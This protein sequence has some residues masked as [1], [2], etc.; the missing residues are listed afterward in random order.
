[1]TGRQDLFDESMQLGHSAAWDLKW[2]RAI[3]YYRKAL[4][5]FPE[6]P[7]ALSSLGLALLETNQLPDALAVYRQ[8]ARLTPDDPVPIERCAEIFERLGQPQEAINLRESAG[9]LYVRRK[10]AEKALECWGHV[11]RLAP[12]SLAARSRLALTYER[13][14]RRREAVHE[15]LAVASILQRSGKPDRGMEAVQRAQALIPGNPD[16]GHVM[17]N[18]REGKALPPASPPR[19]T[20][21]PLR[22]VE[23]GQALRSETGPVESA[24]EAS[25]PEQDGQRQALTLLAGLLFE[26]ASEEAESPK[27]GGLAALG[28]GKRSPDRDAAARAVIQRSLTQ[29]IDMQTRG[30]KK[31]ALRE[32]ENAL[33]AGLDNP[34]AHFNVGILYKDLGKSD[35]AAKHL[36]QAVGHPELA[37]GAHLALGRLSQAAGDQAEAARHLVQVL[38][39][40]DTLSVDQSQSGQLNQYYDRLQASLQEGNQEGLERLIDSTLG[41]LSGPNWLQQVRAA[42]MTVES[43]APGAEVTP[44][45]EMFAVGASDR[46]FKSLEAID[47]LMASNHMEAA[48]E[49]ALIALGASPHYLPI[50]LRMAE[51]LFKSGRHEHAMRKLKTVAETHRVRG[52][53]REATEVYLRILNFAPVDLASRSRLIELLA[54]QA[55]SGE[56]LEQFVSLAD[57]YRQMAQIDEARRALNDA[58]RL[59]QQSQ[60]EQKWEIRI[61]RELGDIELSRLDWRKAL[62]TFEQI[63]SL[64]PSDDNASVQLI[65]LNL[66]L[67]QEDAAAAALDRHLERLVA[68]GHPDDALAYLEELA[69][70]HPGKQA[71]HG[72]LADAYRAAGRTAD[73]IAQYDALGEIQLDAGQLADAIHTIRTIIGLQ[74][75]DLEG[76]HELLRNLEASQ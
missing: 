14:G 18:L 57:L 60:V 20:T 67:G 36:M 54:A 27:A 59:A 17:R 43:E 7:R 13:M 44:I 35:E 64:D 65:D 30:Q 21:G 69:R 63:T 46:V 33:K 70:E 5:E 2:D 66:R 11:A 3:G 10:D 42:R 40:A 26:D 62:R 8:T 71:L 76:Y 38:R 45:A 23:V 61:L 34:A 16:A 22:M 55:R 68:D 37:F 1:M 41:L 50:H 29:A 47:G 53:V 74:P 73:A 58:L 75:P 49:E 19:G 51:I 56:A 12:E 72:R 15:Y 4:A 39:M 32:F 24:E 6:E 31:L 28:R 9:E 52:E 48:M 25:D